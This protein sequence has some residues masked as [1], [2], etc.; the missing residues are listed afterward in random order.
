VAGLDDLIEVLHGRPVI[1][2]DRPADPPREKPPTR[3]VPA[4]LADVVGQPAARWALEVAAAGGHHMLLHGPPGVGKTMLAERLTGLLP[5]LTPEESVEV[6]ALH[7]LAGYDMN[8]GLILRPPYS[9]PHHTATM[10]AMVGGGSKVARPGAISMAHRG[11]LFMDEAPEFSVTVL[12][13]LRTPM[14]SGWVAIAR[15]H[16]TVRYPSRFQ[17]LL[18]A[19]PCPC[20]LATTPGGNCRCTPMQVRRYAQRLSGP[21]LDRIDIHQLLSQT[22]KSVIGTKDEL[23]E[24]SAVVAERVAAARHLQ[25]QRWHGTG[26]SV[27]AEV[28]GHVLRTRLASSPGIRLL[29]DALLRGRVSSRGVDKVVRLAQT[30]ADLAGRDQVTEDD[31]AAAM[32]L[33]QGEWINQ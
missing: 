6:S 3:Q 2:A 12:E 24:P 7:S 31:F 21:I 19:N 33:N 17:L 22:R 27:N 29:D 15:S 13:A 8:D 14:E 1:K 9:A 30:I 10:A 32:T 28:P 26:W 20:G 5:D 23:G 4:D 16:G 25:Y 11:V 18:A